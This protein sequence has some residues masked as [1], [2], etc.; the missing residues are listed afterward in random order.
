[1]I[2]QIMR[3]SRTFVQ[4]A[5]NNASAESQ[6]PGGTE[7]SAE[8]NKKRGKSRIFQKARVLAKIAKFVASVESRFPGGT[9]P[10]ARY[11]QKYVST[12]F[13]PGLKPPRV[14]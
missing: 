4:I 1:M 8:N 7:R 10:G 5:E 14:P 13:R 6:V 12:I 11:A 3:I 2:F 9:E